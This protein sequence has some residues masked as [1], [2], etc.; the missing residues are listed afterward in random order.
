MNRKRVTLEDIWPDVANSVSSLLQNFEKGLEGK[1]YMDI[2]TSALLKNPFFD[3]FNHSLQ[4]QFIS[5]LGYRK[6]YN[7]CTMPRPLNS[8]DENGATFIGKELYE[9]MKELL[10]KDVKVLLKVFLPKSICCPRFFKYFGKKYIINRKPE[11]ITKK[12]YSLITKKSGSSL[13]LLSRCSTTS[14]CTW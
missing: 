3:C 8:K 9:N 7:Y 10:I 11:T 2:Y 13:S 14:L 1:A 4:N 12:V 5:F 6:V